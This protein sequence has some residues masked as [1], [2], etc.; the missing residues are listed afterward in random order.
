MKAGQ[1]NNATSFIEQIDSHEEMLFGDS[2]RGLNIE[3]TLYLPRA[4][5]WIYCQIYYEY[6]IQGEQVF[7]VPSFNFQTYKINN[8]QMKSDIT[9][10]MENPDQVPSEDGLDTQALFNLYFDTIKLAIYTLYFGKQQYNDVKNF[11]KN[12][13]TATFGDYFTLI[14]N[15]TISFLN[16]TNYLFFSLLSYS[17]DVNKTLREDVY[18][19][20]YQLY[21]QYWFAQLYDSLLVLINMFNIIQ[22]TTISRRV[23]LVFKLI[24]LTAPYLGYL[25]LS[26]VI[27][28]YLMAQVMW[29]VYGDKLSYF[30]YTQISMMYTLA[31]FDLK[32]MYLGRDFMSANQYSVDN[33]WLLVLILL[34]AASAATCKSG[35]SCAR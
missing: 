25:V 12:Y 19:N 15:A 4:N 2:A 14:L 1:N 6:G 21:R 13:M 28:L 9:Y 32:S 30:R 18:V 3:V 27:M 29:Q 10:L 7:T 22:F 11:L 35:R 26:Y 24:A 16:I 33:Y 17:Y 34:L 8:Y 31:L 5:W 23:S 20:S